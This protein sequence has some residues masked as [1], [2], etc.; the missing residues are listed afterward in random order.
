MNL[1]GIDDKIISAVQAAYL[2]REPPEKTGD[3]GEFVMG[4]TH[5]KQNIK[6]GIIEN[7]S[8]RA[9]NQSVARVETRSD[10]CWRATLLTP[11]N[12]P[13]SKIIAGSLDHAKKVV[14]RELLNLG[15]ANNQIKG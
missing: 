7:W 10:D 14:E 12:V 11:D 13:V 5:N 3:T 2:W 9:A 6:L 15:W 1:S 8:L 4:W